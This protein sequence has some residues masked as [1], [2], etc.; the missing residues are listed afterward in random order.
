[1]FS[2]KYYLGLGPLEVE[3]VN[4]QSS[5]LTYGFP[6]V[7]AFV[8]FAHHLDRQ[9]RRHFARQQP[10]VPC[11]QWLGGV[12]VICHHSEAYATPAK[13]GRVHF[14]QPR[15]PM[16][17]KGAKVENSASI[18]QVLGR[19]RVSLVMQLSDQRTG[20]KEEAFVAAVRRYVTGM[21]LA[22]GTIRSAYAQLPA[23]TFTYEGGEHP[24]PYI[25]KLQ[26]GVVL[27]SREELLSEHWQQLRQQQ[28]EAS[29]LDALLDLCALHHQPT[30]KNKTGWQQHRRHS[31]WLVPMP[32]GYVAHSPL[33][34]P[35]EVAGCRDP[36]VP[37]CFVEPLLGMGEWVAGWRKVEQIDRYLWR[38]QYDAGRQCYRFVCGQ[39]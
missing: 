22:G 17:L 32:L 13:Y 1:M 8:G 7:G 24:N 18:P 28:P 25:R 15:L 4:L 12:A 21:R 16:R 6:G 27:R 20:V 30:V 2:R 11:S 33:F 35:G 26:P 29:L 34:A 9:L 19:M 3:G 23:Q 36:R 37:S 5:A 14:H 38:S 10:P 31:G 39:L